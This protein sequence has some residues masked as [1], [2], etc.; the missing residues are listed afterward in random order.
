MN[1]GPGVHLLAGLEKPPLRVESVNLAIA[2]E[3]VD[4][5]PLAAIIRFVL[6][7]IRAADEGVRADRHLV[8]EPHLFF[9]ILIK[10]GPGKTNDDY[11]HPEMH[12]IAAIAPGIAMSK[13]DHRGK[14]ILPG[15]AADDVS[16]TNEF[17]NHSE[18]N[19]RR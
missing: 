7:R 6:L 12:D 13:M 10:C 9:F 1:G 4:N 3:D 18:G 11:D 8:A 14:K 5:S 19:E 2:F 15:V 16:A 17:R